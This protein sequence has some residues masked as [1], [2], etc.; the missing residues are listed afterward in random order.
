MALQ[1]S[2]Q[3]HCGPLPTTLFSDHGASESRCRPTW[4][5]I[6]LHKGLKGGVLQNLLCL[7]DDF[8]DAICCQQ[9]DDGF[10]RV[11]VSGKVV[12][13]AIDQGENGQHD[14]PDPSVFVFPYGQDCSEPSKDLDHNPRKRIREIPKLDHAP[15][16]APDKTGR[17]SH[18]ELPGLVKFCIHERQFAKPCIVAGIVVGKITSIVD[19]CLHSR[20]VSEPKFQPEIIAKRND[21]CKC[22]V[23]PYGPGGQCQKK[24]SNGDQHSRR[25]GFRPSEPTSVTENYA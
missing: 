7:S 5:G 16:Y 10:Y 21:A 4:Q 17:V 25:A 2:S 14:K 23:V 19:R 1:T 20:S 24:S 8:S 3:T 11:P 13:E 9:N 18:D 22:H 12:G 15:E 6:K